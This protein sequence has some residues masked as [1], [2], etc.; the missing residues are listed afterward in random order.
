MWRFFHWQQE[1]C[2]LWSLSECALTYAYS[3]VAPGDPPPQAAQEESLGL[4]EEICKKSPLDSS[5]AYD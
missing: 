4:F 1:R 5:I 2:D 3:L